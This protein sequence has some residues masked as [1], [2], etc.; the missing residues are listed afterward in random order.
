MDLRYDKRADALYIELK[1]G[2]VEKTVEISD[3]VIHDLNKKGDILG[4]ELLNVSR[5]SY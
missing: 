2:K 4:I 5:I 1:K 3:R